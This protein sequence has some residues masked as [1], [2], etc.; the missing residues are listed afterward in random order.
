MKLAALAALAAAVVTLL[1]PATSEASPYIRYGVQ[2]DAYLS[3]GP[4]L[5]GRL[6]TLDRLG[7]KLVRYT[8][9]WRQI[10]RKKP[11]R[12]VNPGDPAY[13]WSSADAVLTGLH[14]HKIDVIVTLFGAPAWAN[15][16]R[17]ANGLPR[18]KYSLS[19]FGLAVA[20]RYPWVRL[21]EIWNEPNLRRFLSPNS[22][23][24][25]VQRLLNPTYAVLKRERFSNRVAGGATSPRPTPSGLSPVAFMRGMR[26]AHARLDAY[27]HHPYPVTRGERPYRFARNVCRYCKGVLTLANLPVLL[28]EVRRDFGTKRI[29]LT[30]Y[31]YQTNPPDPFGVSRSVQAKYVAEAAVR[32]K[33]ARFVDVLIHFMVRDE[34]QL[35]GWQSGF[36]SAAGVSKPAFNSFMLP[37]VQSGRVGLRTTIWGQVRPGKGRRWY[38][39][40]RLAGRRWVSIGH[41]T[42]TNVFGSYTRV[43]RAPKGM[44]LRILYYPAGAVSR[45]RVSSRPIV[46]H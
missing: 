30:E 2:D 21:W 22:P 41:P 27:S 29:W 45:E 20:R 31:G 8:V 17:G 24:L 13:D 39:L 16:G 9:D 36:F 28:K 26:A 1:L 4:R 35:S 38:R 12:A 33:S 11:R 18:S 7:A 23:R 15:G 44:R 3:P 40:Q 6:D 25:Y 5:E 14:A 10:A 19:A 37:I 32:A 46:V 43:I 34:P 42:R